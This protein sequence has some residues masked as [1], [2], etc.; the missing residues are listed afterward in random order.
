MLLVPTLDIELV[1]KFDDDLSKAC[2]EAEDKWLL[3]EELIEVGLW[4]V[5]SACEEPDRHATNAKV[6]ARMAM[7]GWV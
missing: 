4:G 7:S 3:A 2:V 5:I 1:C 6:T